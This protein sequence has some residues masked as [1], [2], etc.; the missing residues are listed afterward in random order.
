ML[1]SVF[2]GQVEDPSARVLQKLSVLLLM[3]SFII[4]K[5]VIETKQP[6][7]GAGVVLDERHRIGP[8]RV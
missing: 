1:A 3:S 6:P 4:C 2:L 7:P 8:V 5:R